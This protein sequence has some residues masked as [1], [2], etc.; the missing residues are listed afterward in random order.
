MSEAWVEAAKAV[1]WVLAVFAAY[2][3][4]SAVAS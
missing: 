2:F 4:G 3:A 1:F